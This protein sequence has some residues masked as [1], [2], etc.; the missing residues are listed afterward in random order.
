MGGAHR[1]SHIAASTGGGGLY[2][3]F[4]C[5]VGTVSSR[6]LADLKALNKFYQLSPEKLES[7]KS[8]LCACE[9]SEA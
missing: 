9:I 5:R 2:V 4:G 1:T 3:R 7:G 8:Y 6:N